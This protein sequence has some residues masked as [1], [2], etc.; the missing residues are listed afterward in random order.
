MPKSAVSWLTRLTPFCSARDT[1]D[2]RKRFQTDSLRVQETTLSEYDQ[3]IL[4]SFRKNKVQV[5]HKAVTLLG[6]ERL[7]PE[8]A[9][10]LLGT[11]DYSRNKL[12]EKQAES[13]KQE[14]IS[15]K[16]RIKK[17]NSK[18]IDEFLKSNP[19]TEDQKKVP[20]GS[21]VSKKVL[22][23]LGED[24]PALVAAQTDEGRTQPIR[25]RPK[26]NV[27]TGD[28]EPKPKA[29]FKTSALSF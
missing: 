21:N 24:N 20:D 13:I 8:K 14:I 3:G 26:S 11:Y 2:T 16:V 12:K 17:E 10:R 25:N 23:L 5:P 22:R 6:D 19:P 18:R 4:S 1:G 28:S 7:F 9:Q 15:N 27:Q 29:V